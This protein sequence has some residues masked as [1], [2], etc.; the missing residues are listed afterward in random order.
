MWNTWH[1]HNISLNHT[2]NTLKIS[3]FKTV[4]IHSWNALNTPLKLPWN[5]PKTFLQH[6]W[7]FLI[8]TPWKLDIKV[9][10]HSY[11]IILD[12]ESPWNLITLQA[13][14]L[15][16]LYGVVDSFSLFNSF[17]KFFQFTNV[18]KVLEIIAAWTAFKNLKST[19][20]RKR[21]FWNLSVKQDFKVFEVFFLERSVFRLQLSISQC[22]W[23]L[24]ND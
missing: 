16:V 12:S 20:L 13:K 11:K 7:N 6:T 10:M 24:W 1:F 19:V 5:T 4:L 8:K 14:L 17:L 9:A 21:S 3:T 2:W 18:F 15:N 23:S 22:P